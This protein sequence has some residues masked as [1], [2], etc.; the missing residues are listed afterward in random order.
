MGV[1]S[2][3]VRSGKIR[4]IGHSTFPASKIVEAQWTAR[5]R[6]LERFVT[7]QPPYSI[8]TR[9]IE[10]DVL[11]TCSE[12][13]LGVMT[14]SPLAGG[15]LTGRYG[16]GAGPQGPDS[17]AR[18]PERFDMSS[19]DNQRKLVAVDRLNQ[20]ACKAGVTLIELAISFV[21]RHRSVTSAIIGPI[22]IEHLESQLSGADVT[23]SNDVLDEIDEI[24]APGVTINP[25]DNAWSS[26]Y[27]QRENRRR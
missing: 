2:D 5:V 7:E 20:V 21:L 12:Y 17:H 26:P 19:V 24:V 9:A 15:W 6:R 18:P 4:Y 8:L 10:T 27:L 14:Y 11:P 25:A 16:R 3:L 1:L 23:L 13:G 22:S